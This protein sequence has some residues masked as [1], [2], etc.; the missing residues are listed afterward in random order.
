MPRRHDNLLFGVIIVL[1]F[2][3]FF[4]LASASIGL[5]FQDGAGLS[6]SLGKQLLYGLGLG[7]IFFF[8]ARNVPYQVWGRV[9]IP[10]F[11]F[12]LLLSFLVFAPQ[13]GFSAGGA[14]RWISVGPVFFQPAEFLKFGFIVY[15]SSWIARRKEHVK[16]L[17]YG[18]F[19]FL[20]LLGVTSIVF[21]LQP[22][23]GTLG[24]LVLAAVALFFI[25]GGKVKH[26]LL[27][28]LLLAV[29]FGVLI[30]LAPYRFSR[31]AVFL[32]PALDPQDT[33]Y[34]I[35]QSLIALGTG[36]WWGKGFGMGR[37]KSSFLP[38]PTG[39]SI[40]SVFGEEFGF[41]GSSALIVA[42]LFFASRGF[43][44]S[45]KA[46]DAFGRLLGAG[47]VILIMIQSFVNIAAMVGAVPLTGIP[48][49]FISQGGSALAIT[50]AEMGILLNISKQRTG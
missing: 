35:R 47:I 44:V 20:L 26:I 22:D 10:L 45:R 4:I 27:V 36:G 8:L 11:L 28:A 7:G 16:T 21:I 23:I 48:L 6:R 49:T 32:Q 24:V 19:P 9:A 34:H 2:G 33:G 39:D 31:L 43:A 42:F 30:Y 1:L 17:R 29:L 50:L 40:F 3:G 13:V 25:G 37:Q 46:P 14:R 18:F 41:V 38:E 15:L 5:L 12:T